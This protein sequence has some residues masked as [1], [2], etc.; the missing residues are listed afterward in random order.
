MSM[1]RI[2][3]LFTGVT[4]VALA[5]AATVTL[6]GPASAAP[7]DKPLP[8][9]ADKSPGPVVTPLHCSGHPHSN[10][11]TRANGP[12]F[13]ATDVRIRRF[14]H[15]ANCAIPD[16]LGQPN[17]TVDYH[18]WD[19]GDPVTRN[20]QTWDT[21]TYLRDVTTGVSGWVS[22]ALLDLAPDGINRGSLVRC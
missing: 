3:S 8:V 19:F 6:A 15:V 14:P 9:P 4:M 5:V 16:G 1:T 20:G 13:D 7:D 21:W 17:H 12:F 11:D 22:D 10:K 18:C 2:R